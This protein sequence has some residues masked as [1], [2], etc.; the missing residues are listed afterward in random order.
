MNRVVWVGLA[1][2]L[3]VMIGVPNARADSYQPAFTCGG[4]CSYSAAAASF[5]TAAVAE[6]HTAHRMSR[7]SH[8]AEFAGASTGDNDGDDSGSMTVPP[9]TDPGSGMG[10]SGSSGSSSS[11]PTTSATP[12]PSSWVLMLLGASLLFLTRKRFLPSVRNT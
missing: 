2:F 3:L 12:E 10:S 8:A 5:D 7:K 11:S 1:V 6:H 9:A 4:G